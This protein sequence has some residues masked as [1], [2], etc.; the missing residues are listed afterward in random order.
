MPAIRP[1]ATAS[2]SKPA[3]AAA[4]VSADGRIGV[5]CAVLAAA[6][7][8]GECEGEQD[9]Q[10]EFRASVFSLVRVGSTGVVTPGGER[11]DWIAQNGGET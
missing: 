2:A 6:G 1:A 5:G 3:V 4:V 10:S 8:G 11:Y 7:Q 9:Q